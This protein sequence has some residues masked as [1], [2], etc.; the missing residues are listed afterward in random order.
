MERGWRNIQHICQVVETDCMKP[1]HSIG[2]PAEADEEDEMNC[3]EYILLKEFNSMQLNL[4]RK[5][6]QVDEEDEEEDG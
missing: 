5:P 6:D 3:G 2:T 4:F 1:K